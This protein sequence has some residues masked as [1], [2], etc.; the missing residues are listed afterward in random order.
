M[1]MSIFVSDTGTVY[2]AGQN[3]AGDACIY[4][5]SLKIP[6]SGGGTNAA[7]ATS[8]FVCNGTAYTGGFY[9]GQDI[10]FF[11]CYWK[12]TTMV[13]L[14]GGSQVGGRVNSIFVHEG[15][16]Y[17]AGYRAADNSSDSV[18]CYWVGTTR[19]DLAESTHGSAAHGIFVK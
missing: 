9:G 1:A 2:T 16:V 15:T 8:I 19:V 18:A 3:S 10:G 13:D 7:W 4:E 11:P 14:G 6:L 17:T 12:G 5:G